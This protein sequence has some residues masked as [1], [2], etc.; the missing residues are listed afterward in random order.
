MWQII[1]LAILLVSCAPDFEDL[2]AAVIE[3]SGT[4]REGFEYQ[5]HE[6]LIFHK[7][8]LYE[9]ILG[10]VIVKSDNTELCRKRYDRK[11]Q[12]FTE[13]RVVEGEGTVKGKCTSLLEPYPYTLDGL[14]EAISDNHLIRKESTSKN[15][16]VPFECEKNAS[17]VSLIENCG[18]NKNCMPL[19]DAS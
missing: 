10:S 13:N 12:K 6:M 3:K 8:E 16:M 17:C 2:S 11:E 19:V 9:A 1:I 5:Y 4:T 14:K 15:N 18:K 7:G